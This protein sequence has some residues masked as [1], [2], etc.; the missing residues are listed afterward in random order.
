MPVR[1]ERLDGRDFC[2]DRVQIDL[3]ADL[4]ERFARLG[5]DC[6]MPAMEDV[7]VFA[8]ESVELGHKCCLEP[9]RSPTEIRFR[10]LHR[11][12]EVDGVGLALAGR[13]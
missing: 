6:P 11:N 1:L 2:P 4:S 9:L 7:T 5:Q 12:M 8:S 13:I 3:A 10:S